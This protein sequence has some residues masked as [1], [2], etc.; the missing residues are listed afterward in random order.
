MAGIDYWDEETVYCGRSIPVAQ[1]L[2]DGWA[3]GEVDVIAALD[4]YAYESG[5]RFI[6]ETLLHLRRIYKKPMYRGAPSSSANLP[7]T[8]NSVDAVVKCFRSKSSSIQKEILKNSIH[9]LQGEYDIHGN[10]LFANKQD[11]IGV[12][13]LVTSRLKMRVT[14]KDF[15]TY[16][17]QITP[18]DF[19]VDMKIG[20]STISNISHMGLP[21]IP[22]YMWS[23]SQK[24][25]NP[26]TARMSL[27]CS[28]LWTIIEQYI[29]EIS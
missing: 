24:A 8:S 22:Y 18:D 21:D 3:R 29:Y 26:Q 25:R 2:I 5:D 15:P 7:G 19:P 6:G 10:A 13:L 17:E 12:Y 28:R 1:L 16:A 20:S 27:I 9:V 11:W 23:D 4:R 14:Q